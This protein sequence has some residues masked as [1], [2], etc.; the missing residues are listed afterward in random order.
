MV[1]FLITPLIDELFFK[2]LPTWKPF[3]VTKIKSRL[4]L[5][6]AKATAWLAFKE[7]KKLNQRTAF[8]WNQ[9]R[10]QF[11]CSL[12]ARKFRLNLFKQDILRFRL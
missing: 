1:I 5:S 6:K 12:Y 3:K 9:S 10:L 11:I 7:K 2:N 4:S 8:D